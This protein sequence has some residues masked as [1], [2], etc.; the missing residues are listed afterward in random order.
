MR[1][2]V[3]DR[4]RT[5]PNV[6]NTAKATML[7]KS[8]KVAYKEEQVNNEGLVSNFSIK[9]LQG[10]RSAGLESAFHPNAS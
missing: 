10:A 7:T 6:Y 5:F 2:R 8:K 4:E 1:K 9:A 3:D